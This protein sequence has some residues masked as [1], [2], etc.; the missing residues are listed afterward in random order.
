MM[1]LRNRLHRLGRFL[2]GTLFGLRTNGQE[3][4]TRK[5]S[6]MVVCNHISELD[7]PV[8]GST[9]PR[10]SYFMAKREL[11]SRRMGEFYMPRIGAFPVNRDGVD[12]A[13][14]R[15][16][17]EV[18]RKGYVLVVF[19]EGTRSNDGQPLPVKPGVGL[20]AVRSGVP[21]LPAFVW[22]TDHPFRSLLRLGRFT[23]TY[24]EPMLPR[25][26]AEMRSRGGVRLVAE[27]IMGSIRRI[28]LDNGYIAET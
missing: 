6:L 27:E 7:P 5:G 2:F 22:G 1:F 3:V 13:A 16:G 25:L 17:L 14:L 9:I 19:P 12:T 26:I 15:T 10:Q 23:V 20:L 8:L 4:L 11:F 28:G 24:G 21:V 18:L